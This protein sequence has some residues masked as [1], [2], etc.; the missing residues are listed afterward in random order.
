MNEQQVIAK[1][2]PIIDNLAIKHKWLNGKKS[3]AIAQVMC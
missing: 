1:L 3:M 2:K